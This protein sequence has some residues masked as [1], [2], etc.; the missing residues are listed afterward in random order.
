MK[1]VDM[2]L[3]RWM[4]VRNDVAG[5]HYQHSRLRPQQ[6]KTVLQAVTLH[7]PEKPCVMPG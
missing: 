1:E 7:E 5:L 6:K 2:M 3:E 4:A